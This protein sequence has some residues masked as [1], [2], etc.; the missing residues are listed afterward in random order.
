MVRN[1]AP[2]FEALRNGDCI[3]THR[4]YVGDI[5]AGTGT[6]SVFNVTQYAINPGQQNLFQWLSRIASNYESYK[7]EARG[8]R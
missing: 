8:G 6:P 7:F 5:S 3:I 2:R 4:E 1:S